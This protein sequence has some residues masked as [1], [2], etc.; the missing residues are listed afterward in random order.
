MTKRVDRTE[1]CTDADARVRLQHAQLYLEVAKVAIMNKRPDECTIATGNAVLAAIAASDAICCAGAKRRFRG[2]SHRQAAELLEEVTGDKALSLALR[3][4]IDLK[5]EGHY[6]LGNIELNRD[7]K[8]IRRAERLVAAAESRIPEAARPF[9]AGRQRWLI[10][11]LTGNVLKHSATRKV[12]RDALT[13]D[14]VNMS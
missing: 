5:D 4:A 2:E 3:E 6:G 1:P 8:A 13:L 14:P 10:S 12:P 11:T 7:K 9:R